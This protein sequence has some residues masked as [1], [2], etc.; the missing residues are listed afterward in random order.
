MQGPLPSRMNA[1]VAI[2][3]GP[4]CYCFAT[5][6]PCC[7]PCA[8]WY[9]PGRATAPLGCL[10]FPGTISILAASLS[11]PGRLGFGFVFNLYVKGVLHSV[12]P[13][14]EI[15]LFITT[16]PLGIRRMFLGGSCTLQAAHIQLQRHVFCV[17]PANNMTRSVPAAQSETELRSQHLC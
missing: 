17:T 3:Q 16:V 10:L 5:A 13:C 4:Y 11:I 9:M 15:S 7:F 12:F 14:E 2:L 6:M 1:G 8:V